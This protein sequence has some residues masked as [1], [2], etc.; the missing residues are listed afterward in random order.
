MKKK[1][2]LSFIFVF[3]IVGI[4]NM[5]GVWAWGMNSKSKSNCIDDG[6]NT[7]KF[8]PVGCNCITGGSDNFKVKPAILDWARSNY[9]FSLFGRDVRDDT[10]YYC[11]V[12]DPLSKI[13]PGTG[14][15]KGHVRMCT[16]DNNSTYTTDYTGGEERNKECSS[17]IP[18]CDGGKHTCNECRD[19]SDCS[20]TGFAQLNLGKLIQTKC[21]LDTNQPTKSC[22]YCVRVN[23][24]G[25]KKIVFVIGQLPPGETQEEVIQQMYGG[26]I[27]TEPFKYLHEMKNSFT[28]A[29]V[30]IGNIGGFNERYYIKNGRPYLTNNFKKTITEKAEQLCGGDVIIVYIDYF[31]GQ[32][33][34]Y[35]PSDKFIILNPGLMGGLIHEL[36]H[37]FD[38]A[39]EYVLPYG[40]KSNEIQREGINIQAPNY[41]SVSG[42]CP[43]FTSK[44]VNLPNC[45]D[46]ADGGIKNKGYKKSTPDSVMNSPF[47]ESRFNVISCAG[48]LQKVLGTSIEQGVNYCQDTLTQEGYA[49]YP[50]IIP[51]GIDA[52]E[53]D[54]GAA[55]SGATKSKKCDCAEGFEKCKTIKGVTCCNLE[56]ESCKGLYLPLGANKQHC[57][58]K[59]ECN[60]DNKP[61]KKKCLGDEGTNTCCDLNDFCATVEIWVPFLGAFKNIAICQPKGCKVD[62]PQYCDTDKKGFDYCCNDLKTDCKPVPDPDVPKEDTDYIPTKICMPNEANCVA[63][64]KEFC[65][66]TLT[67]CCP[68][69][70]CQL[71]PAGKAYC[72]K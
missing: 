45:F 42:T 13:K 19:N 50:G 10:N 38:L 71:D 67:A 62:D 9:E 59:D 22:E 8:N 6:F 34:A 41:P 24:T 54:S 35:A 18:F 47:I 60:K 37:A 27:G 28:F 57:E 63:L 15:G 66:G 4:L 72:S 46:V 61:P 44:G 43:K 31:D 58:A 26:I 2:I 32:E 69:G 51:Q 48:I 55:K 16:E 68:A 56:Y 49:I 53:V 7:Q 21:L 30:P 36:G 12:D 23:G 17:A 14:G 1:I 11:Y 39:D 33:T 64:K 52:C 25:A 3:L 40:R 70:K 65:P 29:Y 20:K 5:G